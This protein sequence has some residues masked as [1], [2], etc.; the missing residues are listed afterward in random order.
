MDT[1]Q[2]FGLK[3]PGADDFVDIDVLNENMDIIDEKCAKESWYG[4]CSTS[5]S[6]SAKVVTTTD[7]DFTL[8]AGHRVKVKFTNY[9]TTSSPTLNVDST[10]AKYIKQY[11]TV[12]P[13]TYTWYSGEVVDFVYDGTYFIIAD[14]GVASTTYYGPTKL[15]SSTSSTSN[16]LAATPYAVKQAYD[17]ATDA[18]DYADE[19]YALAMNAVPQ[20]RKINGQTLDKDIIL[21]GISLK[22]M[23]EATLPAQAEY[24][25]GGFSY[26]SRIAYGSSTFVLCLDSAKLAYS[27]DGLNWSLCGFQFNTSPVSQRVA[28]GAGKFVLIGV[29][30]GS[31]TSNMAAY[32]SDGINW[33]EFTLPVS[34]K[35]DGIYYC[36]NKFILVGDGDNMF[37]STDG[38]TWSQCT[39]PSGTTA[40]NHIARQITYGNGVY[41]AC[42]GDSSRPFWY[43]S[44]GI[45]WYGSSTSA[46]DIAA[47]S[48]HDYSISWGKNKFVAI[49][50]RGSFAFY[51]NDGRTWTK[52]YLPIE[53]VGVVFVAVTYG[54]G[55]FVAVPMYTRDT[56]L[57]SDDGIAWNTFKVF[58]NSPALNTYS[59]ETGFVTALYANQIFIG[60]LSQGKDVAYSTD[61]VT[62]FCNN[63]TIGL[64]DTSDNCINHEIIKALGVNDK[65][66][67]LET[68]S[69][70]GTGIYGSSSTYNRLDFKFKPL[71]LIVSPENN[72]G[73]YNVVRIAFGQ[74]EIN[75]NSA[76]NT[77]CT[78]SAFWQY[79]GR[80]EWYNTSSAAKQLN[81]SGM[82][83]NYW[84]IG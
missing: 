31:A 48:G 25:A 50:M 27:Y 68:G 46:V 35:W 30:S 11:G 16:T 4:T 67:R 47:F 26:E 12:A 62:W 15:S 14:G 49:P 1:T 22:N 59:K 8:K 6:M 34:A 17:H 37:Y 53:A 75:Y 3:K 28:Y 9:N 29:L 74:R 57:Y 7:G 13:L 72:S 69:Y 64:F 36:G 24:A 78:L 58:R 51:S 23:P 65:Q 32:S 33:V 38:N 21:D 2:N 10:G 42:N 18:E 83:Y 66:L 80:L 54:E 71:L 77:V 19:A 44:D 61:G 63:N 20:T 52:I 45:T 55:K 60:V 76:Y 41:V 82:T 43:S 81:I 40:S 56:G 39:R 70:V 73:P 5:Y 84:Y 79:S